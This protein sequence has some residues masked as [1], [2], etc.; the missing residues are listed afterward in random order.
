MLTSNVYLFG[1]S[2]NTSYI[3][4]TNYDTTVPA[5]LWPNFDEKD[6]GGMLTVGDCLPPP[7]LDVSPLL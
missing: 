6:G 1:V 7:S 4:L 2:H 3:H 5:R